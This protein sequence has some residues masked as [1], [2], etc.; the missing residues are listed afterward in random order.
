MHFYVCVYIIKTRKNIYWLQCA[1]TR[2]DYWLSYIVFVKIV[3]L[4]NPQDS[5]WLNIIIFDLRE[6]GFLYITYWEGMWTFWR[7]AVVFC[8]VFKAQ[9]Y[10][11]YLFS[12]LSLCWC[13]SNSN[14][15]FNNGQICCGNQILCNSETCNTNHG[16]KTNCMQMNFKN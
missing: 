1:D 15:A 8:F 2:G 9:K 13:L 11:C 16:T 10:C 7:W 3:W 5:A 6:T 4:W 14:F 12:L